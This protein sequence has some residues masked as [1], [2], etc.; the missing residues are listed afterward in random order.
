MSKTWKTRLSLWVPLFLWGLVIFLF[1]SRPTG[2]ASTIQLQDF[3]IKKTAHFVEYGI[4]ATLAFRALKGSGVK[5]QN[6]YIYAF[7]I[8]LGYA[9]TDEFHQA[10]TPGREPTVRDIFIDASGAAITLICIKNLLPKAP[11]KLKAWASTSGL[12]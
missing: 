10:F 6:A 4:F 1:S 5:P 11:P 12:I 7:L 2:V 3:F 8:T 9:I